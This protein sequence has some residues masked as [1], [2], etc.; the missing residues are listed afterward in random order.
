MRLRNKVAVITGG[1]SG[2]GA[3][4]ARLFA[5][6]G[7]KV[8]VGDLADATSTVREI[9]GG[10]AFSMVIDVT[11]GGRVDALIRAAVERWGGL[12][13]M[14]NNAGVGL[15]KPITEV[16]EGE[17][18]RVFAV[19]VKGLYFG[20]KAA[21]PFLLKRGGGSIINMSSNGGLIGRASDPVYCASKHAV[22]GLTKALAVSYAH[23]NI[24][25]N[26]LCPGP[27]DTPMLWLGVETPEQRRERLPAVLATCP[28]A[29]YASADEVASA[30]LFL[31]SDESAFIT[32]IGLPIDGAKAAGVMP[33]ERYR[34]DFAV[35]M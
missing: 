8:A 35:N 10:D 1:A 2:I 34:L 15:P 31:A 27:I 24:R 12:D 11:A 19:N 33:L 29:R 16:T 28:A 18:D 32:G 17:F 22:M 30:A 14:F 13:I 5:R 7:A 9:G 26:A 23:L 21:L 4:A 6:E 3:A 20:C 25:V